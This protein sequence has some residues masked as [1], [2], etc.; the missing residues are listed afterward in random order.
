MW[1]L[2]PQKGR[3]SGELILRKKKGGFS[4]E[5]LGS[6]AFWRFFASP[7]KKKTLVA[8]MLAVFFCHSET[9]N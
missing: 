8:S 4:P 9:F 3:P 7:K 2:A 5:N 1:R 6:V